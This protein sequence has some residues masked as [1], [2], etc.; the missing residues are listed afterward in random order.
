MA[1]SKKKSRAQKPAA[2]GE[3]IM[4]PPK[5]WSRSWN[6]MWGFLSAVA[7][8]VLIFLVRGEVVILGTVQLVVLIIGIPILAHLIISGL[9]QFLYL[10]SPRL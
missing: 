7:E 8:L 5:R 1:K 2:K 6:V 3:F 9:R 10:I 4:G